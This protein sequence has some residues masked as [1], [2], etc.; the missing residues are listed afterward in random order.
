MPREFAY[1][2]TETV[3]LEEIVLVE[4]F[5]ITVHYM[6]LGGPVLGQTVLV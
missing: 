2:I 6:R 1:K 3:A 5:S 4:P